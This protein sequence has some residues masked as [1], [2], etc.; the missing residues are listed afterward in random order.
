MKKETIESLNI[1]YDDFINMGMCHCNIV[2]Q[3]I[4]RGELPDEYYNYIAENEDVYGTYTAC[5]KLIGYLLYKIIDKNFT[6]YFDYMQDIK[7]HNLSC[8]TVYD[9]IQKYLKIKE[10]TLMETE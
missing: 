3:A 8:E 1:N 4:Y 5:V 6:L 7:K 2:K 10:T 9:Y